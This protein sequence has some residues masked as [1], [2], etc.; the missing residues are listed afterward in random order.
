MTFLGELEFEISPNS[1]RVS[2]FEILETKNP[3][4]NEEALADDYDY[5]GSE[6][7][8]EIRFK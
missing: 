4:K 5:L 1:P 3:D 8:E 2:K 6:E 7:F